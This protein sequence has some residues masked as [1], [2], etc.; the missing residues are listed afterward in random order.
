MGPS[1][2]HFAIIMESCTPQDKPEEDAALNP[3]HLVIIASCVVTLVA[4]AVHVHSNPVLTSQDK[5]WFA[6]CFL[7]IAV[8]ALTEALGDWLNA[9]ASAPALHTV[10]KLLEFCVTPLIPVCL[11]FACGNHKSA[12]VVGAAMVVHAVLELVLLPFGAVFSVTSQ[13]LYQRGSLYL[14]YVFSYVGSFIYLLVMFVMLSRRFRQR[15][16]FTLLLTPLVALVC[17][18]PPLINREVRTSFLGMTLASI[19]LYCYYEGLTQQD[20]NAELAAHNARIAAM[21]QGTIIGMANLIESRDGSTG[22]HVKNTAAY[23]GALAS[24][25]LEAG[26]YPEV[27]TAHFVDLVQKAAPLHDV[28]KIVVPDHILNKPGRLTPDEFEVMKTH[29]A[30]GG[31]IV[32]R[33]LSGVTDPEYTEIAADIASYHHERWDGGG[34]PEGLAGEDIPVS[35]RIMAVADVYDALVSER[36]YKAAMP[37][38][39][40]LAIIE[41]ESGSHFDPQLT[42]LFL[43]LMRKE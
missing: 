33:I 31:V 27:I 36:V 29:A 30:E 38:E 40:A 4:M 6:L 9:S 24:A 2:P 7:G 43:E 26:V 35:A 28:G 15:D 22:E 16:L 5:R 34:Y 18:V 21:Q 12:K 39:Q 41:E 42:G 10:V 8:G 17:V 32:R 20:L 25:A 1:I 19:L 37:P 23:V 13:G 3:F 11:A 14:I